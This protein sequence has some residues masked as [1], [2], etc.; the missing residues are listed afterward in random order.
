MISTKLKFQMIDSVYTLLH[1]WAA[2]SL[3]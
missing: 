1:F 3:S 2:K